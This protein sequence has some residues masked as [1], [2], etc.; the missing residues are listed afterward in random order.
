MARRFLASPYFKKAKR[1]LFYV[2]LP[3]EADT[4]F[5]IRRSLALGKHVFV[6][7]ARADKK[8]SIHGVK[9]FPGDLK[10]GA[11]KIFE[12]KDHCRLVRPS[13]VE[14]AVVPSLGVTAKGDRLGRGAGYYDR[15]L[16]TIPKAKKIGLVFKEQL[17]DFIPAEK[18]DV[19]LHAVISD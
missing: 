15:F 17:L 3:E 11:F 13:E 10:K 14:L 12:P 7:R 2:S 6:P 5:L 9:K 16:K 8:L 1:I 4:A 18:H 19:R